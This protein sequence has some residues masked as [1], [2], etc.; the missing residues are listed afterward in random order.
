MAVIGSP[1][2][3]LERLDVGESGMAGIGGQRT[4]TDPLLRLGSKQR[5]FRYDH[6]HGQESDP[7]HLF[8]RPAVGLENALR[9]T[10]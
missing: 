4:L 8:D 7:H 2:R 5:T 10:A 9:R 3:Q 6:H 1:D